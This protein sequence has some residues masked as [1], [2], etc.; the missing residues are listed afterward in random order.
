MNEK[1]NEIAYTRIYLHL[2]QASSSLSFQISWYTAYCR[3]VDMTQ[4]LGKVEAVDGNLDYDQY[5]IGSILY[6]YPFHVS[7]TVLGT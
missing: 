5:P 1:N 3:L 6:I 7:T 2:S 4:E